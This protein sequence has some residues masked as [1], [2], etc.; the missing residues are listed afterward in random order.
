MAVLVGEVLMK[1]VMRCTHVVQ[2]E[3]LG[4]VFIRLSFLLPVLT[5]AATRLEAGPAATAAWTAALAAGLPV[6]GGWADERSPVPPV[7]LPRV[8][9]F[10]LM[11]PKLSR[12]T[13]FAW[14]LASYGPAPVVEFLLTVYGHPCAR[15]LGLPRTALTLRLLRSVGRA[16]LIPGLYDLTA[17]SERRALARVLACPFPAELAM[18]FVAV[19]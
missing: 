6:P 19:Q 3:A 4:Q 13:E 18:P 9:F 2:A 17:A 15:R 5:A 1:A 14:S 12:V 11:A 16:D 7:P 10:D 8:T